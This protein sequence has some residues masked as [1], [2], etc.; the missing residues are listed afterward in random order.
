LVLVGVAVGVYDV[1]LQ[2]ITGERVVL[3]RY[4]DLE[5]GKTASEVVDLY[6]LTEGNWSCDCNRSLA[7]GFAF[8]TSTCL[9]CRRFIVIDAVP[10]FDDES[11]NRE[12]VLRDANIEYYMNMRTVLDAKKDKPPAGAFVIGYGPSGHVD[13]DCDVCVWDGSDWW[14][15][16]G[17]ELTHEVTHWS[18]IPRKN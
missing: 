17:T 15:S 8:E 2:K 6:S 9:G 3:V 13:G 1:Q 16:C 7:F 10:S 5:T 12:E 4:L 18:H 14:A 11:V